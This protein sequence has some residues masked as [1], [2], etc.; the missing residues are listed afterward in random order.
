MGCR[1]CSEVRGY[2]YKRSH[3][4]A[5]RPTK[6]SERSTFNVVDGR[7]VK[8]LSRVAQLDQ[9]TALPDQCLHS[10]EADVR[11]PRRKSGFV[12]LPGGISP[13]GAPRT[14][15]EPLDSHGS[16]CSAVAMH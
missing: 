4:V 6:I 8:Y 9:R 15:R 16:R 12:E 10:A 1:Q 14:V 3:L 5:L 2:P 7:A 13:P 11:P